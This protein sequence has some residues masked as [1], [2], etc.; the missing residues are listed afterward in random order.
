MRTIKSATEKSMKII[1]IS[2]LLPDQYFIFT[3]DLLIDE[4]ERVEF[5]GLA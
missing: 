3:S 4:Y 2:E 5:T 1:S